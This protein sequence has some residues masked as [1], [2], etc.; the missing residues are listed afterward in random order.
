VIFRYPNVYKPSEIKKH[1]SRTGENCWMNHIIE[2]D[3]WLDS[4]NPGKASSCYQ[5]IIDSF[6]GNVWGYL[7]LSESS[8]GISPSQS[9]AALEKASELVPRYYEIW[10]RLAL[11]YRHTG[12]KSRAREA[13]SRAFMLNPMNSD[14]S[15]LYKKFNS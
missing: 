3:A 1:I 2:G 4:G 14:V 5:R 8:E 15:R 12:D 9:A 13:A 11:L 6:P 10:Y 7:R